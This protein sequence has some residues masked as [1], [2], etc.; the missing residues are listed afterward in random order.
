MPKTPTPP[1]VPNYLRTDI[2]MRRAHNRRAQREAVQGARAEQK[3][4]ARQTRAR[5]SANRIETH[6]VKRIERIERH[7]SPAAVAQL[8]AIAADRAL[9]PKARALAADVVLR[10]GAS[11]KAKRKRQN[12]KSAKHENPENQPG[13]R[14]AGMVAGVDPEINGAPDRRAAGESRGEDIAAIAAL[15]REEIAGSKKAREA[16]ARYSKFKMTPWG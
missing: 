15:R 8:R 14:S 16:K 9:P 5:D 4:D 11:P 2:K 1:V 6:L 7:P 13:K 3:A 10:W 12:G